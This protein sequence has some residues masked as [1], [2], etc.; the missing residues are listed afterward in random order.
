MKNNKSGQLSIFI[1]HFLNKKNENWTQIFIFQLAEK[2]NDPK[3][4]AFLS[5]SLL[6]GW[7]GGWRAGGGARE[8]VFAPSF[9][10]TS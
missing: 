3:I 9:F 5:L 6:S 10:S 7:V 2:M 4:H 8:G 1:F